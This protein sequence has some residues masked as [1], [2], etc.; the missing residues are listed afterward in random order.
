MVIIAIHL[1]VT[2]MS[3]NNERNLKNHQTDLCSR[4]LLEEVFGHVLVLENC[5]IQNVSKLE[6][7]IWIGNKAIYVIGI[8]FLKIFHLSASMADWSQ[9]NM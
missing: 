6:I 8:L 1:S 4:W 2:V 9:A 5:I 3:N 7:I